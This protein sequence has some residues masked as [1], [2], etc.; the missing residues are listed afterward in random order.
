MASS[1]VMNIYRRKYEGEISFDQFQ[2]YL[3]KG[4][5]LLRRSKPSTDP[6]DAKAIEIALEY[7]M[8]SV[9]R[10]LNASNSDY[11]D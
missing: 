1:F 3:N 4:L 7:N 9:M 11:Y 6:Q 10:Q 5:T 2:A 8:E